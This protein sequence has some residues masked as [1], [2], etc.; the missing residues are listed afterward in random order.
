MNSL[1]ERGAVNILLVPL[2]LAVLFFFSALGFGFWAFSGRQEYKN[3][4]DQITAVA[5]NEAITAT[6]QAD[7]VK[8]GEEAKKPYDNYIGPAPFGNVTVNYPKTWSAYVMEDQDGSKPI[9]AYFNPKF[10]PN[11]GEK[12]NAMALRVELVQDSYDK[13]TE[14]FNG[15]LKTKEVTLQPYKLAKVPSVVGSRIEG[16]I[17]ST[18]Q[19]TMIILPLRNM[20]LKIWT[21]SNDFKADLDTHILPNFS[22]VP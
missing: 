19:G 18:K 4:S 21:E 7:A 2:I 14:S 8:Y 10:V 1:N 15:L 17:T 20:T 3:K 16:Q 9:T 11:V 5:V 13:V 22:F 12:E 6:Q